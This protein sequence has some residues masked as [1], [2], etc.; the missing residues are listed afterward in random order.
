MSEKALVLRPAV[1]GTA[2]VNGSE[3]L[4]HTPVADMTAPEIHVAWSILDHIEKVAKAR[5][6]TLRTELMTHAEEDGTQDEKGSS[7]KVMEHGGKVTKQASHIIK[8]NPA[9]L[10]A[11]LNE[12]EIPLKEAGSVKFVP[13][14]KKVENLVAEG[15]VSLDEL[16][17]CYDSKVQYSLRV[18]KPD[19][20][21]AAIKGGENGKLGKLQP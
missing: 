15:R 1:E 11:L 12:K 20:V 7:T 8:I 3:R 9:R 19:Q 2:I 17:D 21:T 5:K 18:V 13:D 14:E 10:T 4:L 16:S 6:A